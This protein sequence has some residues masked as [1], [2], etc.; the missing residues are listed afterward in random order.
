[1][2]EQWK[3]IKDYPNYMVSNLGNVKSLN[4]NGTKKEKILKQRKH[5]NGYMRVQL[6]KNK[7]C[8]DKYI[9]RLVAQEFIPTPENKPHIDHIN[10]NRTDNRVENIRWVTR[11]ENMNN[12]LT[13]NKRLKTTGGY[14]WI[15]EKVG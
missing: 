11:S 12:P 5:T 3:V 7:V 2:V 8:K 6:C 15:Y 10:T 1:M 13:K 4:Y 9:H 14:K